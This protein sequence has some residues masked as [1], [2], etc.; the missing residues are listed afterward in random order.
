MEVYKGLVN[1]IE[2]FGS[3]DG[4]GVRF[5]IF[6]Q[7]CKMRCKYCHNPETWA[8]KCDEAKEWTPQDMFNYAYRYHFY[9]GK[10]MSNGGITVSGGEPL[11]QIDFVIELFKIAKANG[12]HT[13]ID[14]TGQTFSQ[15]DGY[16]EKLDKLMEVT[17]L[18]IVDLKAFD[19]DLHRSLTG[20]DNTNI[21]EFMKYLSKSGKKM[22]IRRVLVPNLTDGEEDLINTRKFIESLE[23]VE[24][25][26]VLPYHTLGL[27]KWQKLKINYP[28]DGYRSPT[29]DEVLRANTL[30][31]TEKYK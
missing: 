26:E 24:K 18:F 2:T 3:V 27:F 6:L 21:L 30:L 20:V 1:T 22:W 19:K 14:T 31:N 5:V 25:V 9:W 7:G 17:D 28:L 4:P 11:L 10:D 12:V 15:D 23:T 8:P 16:L 29:K 13:A